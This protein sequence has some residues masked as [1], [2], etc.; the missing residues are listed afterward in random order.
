MDSYIGSGHNYFLYHKAFDGKFE[1]IPW[2]VNESFGSFSNGLSPT[3]IKNLSLF[4]TGN[5]GSRPLIEKMA[6]NATYK[7]ALATENVIVVME[8][9]HLCVSCRGIKDEN[10]FTSTIQ[11]GGIF[12]E[13]EN[14]NDFFNLIR[15]S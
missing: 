10:S 3:Q 13:K 1:F 9:A 15:K 2:D 7:T 4:Y 5:A 8:A 12:K 14:R 11:Y 6:A